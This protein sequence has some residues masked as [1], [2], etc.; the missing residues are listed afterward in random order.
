MFFGNSVAF[1]L[2]QWM[3]AIW[4]LVSLPFLNPVCTSGTFQF[5]Y[6]WSLG[7]ENFEHYFASMWNERN[8][9]V[10][11]TFFGIAL[12]W[13]WSES[14]PSQSCGHYWV[15]QICWHIDCSTLTTSSFR[16]WNSSTGISSPSLV[17]FIVIFL[18]AHLTSHSRMSGSRWV[19]IPSWFL[20]T[21]FKDHNRENF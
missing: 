6:C 20:V 17:W 21:T 3:L 2:I 1:P 14:W 19:I 12:L 13:D 10:V 7:L 4:S 11:W 15:F 5:T 18:K 8:C 16:I 9:A